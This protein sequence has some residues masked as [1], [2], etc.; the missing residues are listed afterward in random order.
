MTDM[1]P[2]FSGRRNA[3]DGAEGGAVATAAMIAAVKLAPVVGIPAELIVGPIGCGLGALWGL[4]KYAR[5]KFAR[6]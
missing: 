5:K 2:R 1:G 6:K 3:R 4:F